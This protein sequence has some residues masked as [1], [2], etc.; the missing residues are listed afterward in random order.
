MADTLE[1]VRPEDNKVTMS[2]EEFNTSKAYDFR[3]KQLEDRIDAI[4]SAFETDSLIYMTAE[5]LTED[6]FEPDPNF[7]L[8]DHYGELTQGIHFDYLHNFEDVHSMSQGLALRKELMEQQKR[9]QTLED[10]GLEGFVYLFGANL[11]D[12]LAL[13]YTGQ[14]A[15]VGSKLGQLFGKTWYTRGTMGAGLEGT[16]EIG[17]QFLSDAD[18]TKEDLM[19]AVGAGFVGNALFGP[20]STTKLDEGIN[21]RLDDLFTDY[22]DDT[23]QN[24]EKSLRVSSV[25][26]DVLSKVGTTVEKIW[27]KGRFDTA[28]FFER[29]QSETIRNFGQTIF[30]DDT[31]QGNIPGGYKAF[32]YRDLVRESLVEKWHTN[33]QPL[34]KEYLESKYGEISTL[35]YG[36]HANSEREVN[37]FFEMIGRIQW[38]QLDDS[39]FEKKVLQAHK[40]YNKFQYDTLKEYKH[41]LFDKIPFDENY[42][43]IR[44][45][46]VKIGQIKAKFGDNYKTELKGLVSGAIKSKFAQIGETVDPVKLDK[47]STGYVNR[48]LDS[49]TSH[50]KPFVGQ[51]FS[52]EDLKLL[53]DIIDDFK[54][55]NLQNITDKQFDAIEDI[56]AK[57]GLRGAKKAEKGEGSRYNKS[58][59]FLDYNYVH[60]TADGDIISFEDLI[61]TNYQS[62]MYPYINS[63]A[64]EVGLAKAG[65]EGRK[66]AEELI[67]KAEEELGTTR[68]PDLTRLRSILGDMTGTP[69]VDDYNGMMMRAARIM[70]NMGNSLY[71]NQTWFAMASEIGSSLVEGSLRFLKNIP[72]WDSVFKQFKEGKIADDLADELRLFSGVGGELGRFPQYDRFAEDYS[73]GYSNIG[74]TILGKAEKTTNALAEV[75]L[76]IGGIKPFSAM[77]QQ[78]LGTSVLAKL[79]KQLLT[80]TIDPKFINELGV[81]EST[82]NDARKWFGGVGDNLENLSFKDLPVESRQEMLLGL[83][84][85]SNNILQKHSVGSSVGFAGNDRMLKDTWLGK[86]LLFL[87]GFV[88]ESYVKQLGRAV[89]RRDMHMFV[90][91]ISQLTITTLGYY[92]QQVINFAGTEDFKERVAP[93]NAIPSIVGRTTF[94]SILPTYVDTLSNALVDQ[95]V[96]S[97]TRSSGLSNSIVGGN[98]LNNTYKAG[99]GLAHLIS[100]WADMSKSDANAIKAMIPFNNAIAIKRILEGLEE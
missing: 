52:E 81:S 56:Q 93:E 16:L 91:F 99:M 29:S 61:D 34:F 49:V 9:R 43:P 37:D 63:M 24:A 89:K 86:M 57:V 69:N 48:M 22:S 18:R 95:S 28:K 98:I 32:E 14:F 68:H 15:G 10:L 75:S 2:M 30:P 82:L 83:R 100:P 60:T 4:H 72:G 7:Q 23:A 42:M 20:R 74:E 71:L 12:T 79:R 6:S 39:E 46:E 85:F 73:R 84:R 58:R 45:K 8:E 35:K 47:A 92:S 80:D 41:P 65:I 13:S 31:L 54:E 96:F 11:A 67:K 27:E 90:N 66:G 25:A 3:H 55:Q 88:T 33:Y 40:D 70:N 78:G 59:T 50:D 77:M 87:K 53:G 26:S 36:I 17:K 44:F 76:H 5:T 1:V 94:A 38:R 19:F 51:E 62:V 97:Y 64:G 21:K